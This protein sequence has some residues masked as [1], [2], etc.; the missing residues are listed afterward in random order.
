MSSYYAPAEEVIQ[1]YQAHR[2]RNIPTEDRKPFCKICFKKPK[3]RHIPPEFERFWTWISNDYH[4]LEFNGYTVR[5]FR[6]LNRIDPFDYNS[7]GEHATYL[8]ES[9]KFEIPLTPITEL[10]FYLHSLFVATTGFS[11][12][13][14]PQF[15]ANIYL[16]YQRHIQ[17]EQETQ[18]EETELIQQEINNSP[19]HSQHSSHVTTPSQSPPNSPLLQPTPVNMAASQDQIRT[20]LEGIFGANGQR[21]T[22]AQTAITTANT[23]LTTAINNQANA[24]TNVERSIAKVDIFSGTEGEDPIEWL[25]NFNRTAE[26]NR[27]STEARKVQVAGGFMKGIA[28]EWYDTN[29]ATMNQI[30]NT[31]TGTNGNENF[32]DMFQAR[33]ANETK[34]HQWYQELMQLRQQPGES[35][36]V[37]T[38]KFLKLA[39]RVGV[40]DQG[41]K[42]RMYLMGLSPALTPLV[43]SQNP[44]TFAEATEAARRTEIGY[45]FATGTMPKQTTSIT[46]AVLDTTPVTNQ[47]VDEL[48][49][50]LEQLTVNYATLSAALLAQTTTTTPVQEQRNLTQRVPRP[51]PRQRNSQ[52]ICFNCGKPG[53]IIRE[54]NQPRRQN[55]NYNN[56]SRR[57]RFETPRDLHYFDYD[58][59]EYYSEEE[60]EENELYLNGTRTGPYPRS[61]VSKNHRNNNRQ[62]ESNRE[63]ELQ[64]NTFQNAQKP[65]FQTMQSGTYN[66]PF[67]VEDDDDEEMEDASSEEEE[68]TPKI[69]VS[70][71]KKT[72][73]TTTT[74]AAK[75][76][77]KPKYKMK[78]SPLENVTEFDVTHYLQNLPCGLT[79][80]QAA[81]LL[82]KYRSALGKSIRR[83]REKLP[84]TEAN[85]VVSD[86]NDDEATTAAKC[87]LRVGNQV[88]QAIVDS[89]AATS[90]ITMPLLKRLGYSIDR[91]SRLMVVTANGDRTRSLGITDD[92]PIIIKRLKFPTSVQV[93]DSK[94]ELLI[95]GNNWLRRA[96]A[97]LEWKR[98]VLTIRTDRCTEKIP[99]TFTKTNCF[100]MYEQDDGIDHETVEIHYSEESSEEEY[101]PWVDSWEDCP[102]LY[103]NP[104]TNYTYEYKQVVNPAIF[105]A[106]AEQENE[107]NQEWNLEKDLHVGPLDHPQTE[108]FH[109]LLQDNANVCASSQMDIGR[110]NILRHEINTGNH[111][112]IAQS[113]YRGNPVK[114]SSYKKKSLTCLRKG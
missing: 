26:T 27:W 7:F 104:W 114:I 95:L 83:T 80:G 43:Y 69:V 8:L 25:K 33:F 58:Q 57:T 79:I 55:Y 111:A 81:N 59:E 40:T 84:E 93:L 12:Q 45:N 103:E 72:T 49:K 24:Q 35:V 110:T 107:Q 28:A 112:P 36:D 10:C 97:M 54:C 88:V 32:E 78:P 30:W 75:G 21:L 100:R 99:V 19:N 29:K 109:K 98:S 87:T 61:P 56:N 22:T 66:D 74:T 44:A 85:Y 113:A 105:L 60:Y 46:K 47:E 94:D 52:I 14:L 34:K 70:E 51:P 91:P 76:K 20:I 63:L 41:L 13:I 48:T 38:N 96:D 6:D 42:L 4:A 1:H 62:S 3:N 65:S 5:S 18:I 92:L 67:I 23:N 108:V 16:R 77:R 82:P 2:N 31:G 89:G 102:E 86:D 17:A 15:I 101:N 11:T 39:D 106:E 68:E 53:H 73:T 64:N 9:I 71:P 50:K 37:F 90:I